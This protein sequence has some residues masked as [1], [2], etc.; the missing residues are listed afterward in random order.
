MTYRIT[1]LLLGLILWTKVPIILFHA[2][3][4]SSN[5]LRINDTA[6]NFLT[7]QQKAWCRDEG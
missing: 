5:G 4:L 1:A 2:D 3:S 7:M 6:L